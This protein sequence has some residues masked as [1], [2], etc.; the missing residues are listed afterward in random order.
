MRLRLAF[1]FARRELRGSI[2]GFRVFLACL[3]LAVAAIAAVGSTRAA[4]E[5]GLAREGRTILGGDAEIELP[6]RF[7]TADERAWMESRAER[8]S[9]VVALRSMAG[10]GR[11]G[12]SERAL[13]QVR[14]VDPAYPLFGSVSL[15][16]PMP[17]SEALAG[18]GGLPGAVM[19]RALAERLGLD[20]GGRF[21]LGGQGF[22]LGA[23][24]L[25]APDDAAAGF[26]LGPRM[27]VRTADLERAGLL[28]PGS[29]FETKYRLALPPGTDLE[30]LRTEAVGAIEGG[31]FRWRDRRDGA[32]GVR[33][34]I[35]HLG[36]F[37]TLVGLAGL[38]I[39]GVGIS[40]AVRSYLEE[41]LTTIATLK[42]LGAERGTIFLIYS[43]QVGAM[44][45]AG[46]AAGLALGALLPLL[47]AAPLRV[48]LPVPADF[49]FHPAPLAAAALYGALTAGVFTLWPLARTES[50]RPAALFRDAALGSGGWPRLRYMAASGLLLALLVAAAASLSGDARLTLWVTGGLALAALV[51]VLAARLVRVFAGALARRGSGRWPAALRLALRA[52]AGPGQEV[53]VAVLS[54]GLGLAVL[55]A[56]GQ[57]DRNLRDAIARDLPSVAPLFFVLD[58][59]PDQ[60]ARY[61]ALLRNDPAVEGVRV[62]PM[63]RG[64]IT[65][66]N[67]RPA[68]EV[69]GDHWVL[70]GDRGVTYAVT[71]PDGSRIT[72]GRWWPADHAGPPEASFSAEEAAEMG[73]KLG[74]RLTVNVMGRDITATITSFRDVDFSGAA[75]GFV[76]VLSPDALAGAPHGYISTIRAAPEAEARLLRALGRAFPNVTAISVRDAV[77]KLSEILGAIAA[78]LTLGALATLAIG[79]LVLIGVAAA[80]VRAR[81]HEASVLRALGATRGQILAAFLLRA[82]LPG[83]AAAVVALLVGS[84]AA[85]AVVTLVMDGD[86]RLA[87]GPALLIVGGGALLNVLAGGL[88]LR[89]A[90]NARPAA[91]LRARE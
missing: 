8:V 11:G 1:R 44:A 31:A 34:F 39:G 51:L 42:A 87:P 20:V 76:L 77:G 30:V 55:A 15:S 50:I 47:L 78:A 10:T 28:E 6:Y 67:G 89:P 62:A 43:L 4:L 69:A 7:A 27:I 54:L 35:R 68:R 37:L 33:D 83:A 36:S 82:A 71:P 60:L 80:G 91:I 86:F 18:D 3:A 12:D 14:G 49:G 75:M 81:V 32:P 38:I 57:I 56:I 25:S 9:E 23:I 26:A 90:L 24:L 88:F 48:R 64:I 21:S 53:R 45:A 13:T 16:P 41:R 85:W 65:R 2:A 79:A 19:E 73:L 66:L 22:R 29:L 46:I 58:I 84:G 5:S 40:A 74:D 72:A 17:L 59:Q 52:A 63:L 70:R 61:E